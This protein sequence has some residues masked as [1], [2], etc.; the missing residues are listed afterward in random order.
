MA[1]MVRGKAVDVGFVMQRVRAALSQLPDARRGKNWHYSMADAG[2]SAFS[3]FF[4]Q[5]PSFLEYQRRMQQTQGRNN[6]Q[7]LFGV[8]EIPCD[9][10]ICQ[11]LDAVPAQTLEPLYEELLQCLMGEGVIQRYRVLAGKVLLALDGVTY[12][13]SPA[14]HCPQCTHRVHAG[15]TVYSHSALT[16]VL[17]QPDQS[18]VVGLA[19]EFITPQDSHDKQDCELNA[20]QRWLQ[21]HGPL[22]SDY[23]SPPEIVDKPHRSDP[24]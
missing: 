6:A 1:G 5:F 15:R 16:P 3:V 23:L 21:R 13:S 17:V 19:P 14:L 8:H 10:Q 24:P 20:A 22:M 9:N 2:L 12:F 7:S 11:M 4:M 18:K